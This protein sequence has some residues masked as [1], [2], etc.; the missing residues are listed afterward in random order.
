MGAGDSGEHAIFSEDLEHVIKA[1]SNASTAD[2]HPGRV[3]EFGRFYAERGGEFF[4]LG[5]E[6]EGVE[7]L[8]AAVAVGEFG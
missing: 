3:D 1:G 7:S 2:R 5:F 8:E 4:E 6:G